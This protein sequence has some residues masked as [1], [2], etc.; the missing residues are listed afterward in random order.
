MADN[1][2]TISEE[3]V[4]L[5]FNPIRESL[6]AATN[7]INDST[8]QVRDLVHMFSTPPSRAELKDY[9]GHL[10]QNHNTEATNKT[11]VIQTTIKDSIQEVKDEM[12]EALEDLTDTFK[13]VGDGLD[14]NN[15]AMLELI[16][17]TKDLNT[18][19]TTTVNNLDNRINLLMGI[20]AV[21]FTL[22]MIAWASVA[23]F[24][25]IPKPG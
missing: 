19:L 18:S 23:Y 6:T 20:V 24:F 2:R 22:A 8:I 10:F 14:T 5:I 4:K 11:T 15:K 7:A 16:T 3:M 12:K 21:A 1:E 9:I 17:G 25:S 13:K